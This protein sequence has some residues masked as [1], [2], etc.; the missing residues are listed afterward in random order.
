ME[1]AHDNR[2]VL[3]GMKSGD[4]KETIWKTDGS[5][6]TPILT[7]KNGFVYGASSEKILT[8]QSNPEGY[9]LKDLH[10]STQSIKLLYSDGKPVTGIIRANFSPDGNE[11]AITTSENTQDV[12][13][14]VKYGKLIS[15]AKKNAWAC[16]SYD[17]KK[18]AYHVLSAHK[19]VVMDISSGKNEYYHLGILDPWFPGEFSPNGSQ[20]LMTNDSASDSHAVFHIDLKTRKATDV[21]PVSWKNDELQSFPFVQWA[22]NGK[23][24]IFSTDLRFRPYVGI[25]ISNSD[26]S[27]FHEITFHAITK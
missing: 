11:L 24:I 23:H 5:A 2:F 13:W 7:I 12:L 22:G 15:L 20:I 27:N 14:R 19:V 10:K 6:I 16:W 17:N 3:V 8:S 21:T 1:Y 25:Y 18:L 9:S 26:G 4:A